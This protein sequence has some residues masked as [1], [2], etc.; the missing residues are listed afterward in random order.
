MN[1]SQSVGMYVILA[2]VALVFISSI[3]MT[4]PATQTS[5]ISYMRS[6]QRPQI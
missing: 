4:G 2:M 1:K 5:E 6:Q 3:F